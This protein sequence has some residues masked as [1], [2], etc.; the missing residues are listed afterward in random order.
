MT[1]AYLSA[2]RPPGSVHHSAGRN[3]CLG[4][5]VTRHEL[6][7]G[8]GA[9]RRIRPE[10]SR[11]AVFRDTMVHEAESGFLQGFSPLSLV[12]VEWECVAPAGSGVRKS[13][14]RYALTS[15]QIMSLSDK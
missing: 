7:V 4:V 14:T 8:E 10:F 5:V 2:T 9:F 11:A 3:C 1:V 15:W 13:C 12:P 6:W